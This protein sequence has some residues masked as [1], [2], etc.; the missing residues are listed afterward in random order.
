MTTKPP[1]DVVTCESDA[2]KDSSSKGDPLSSSIALINLLGKS[3]LI[4]APSMPEDALIEAT[5][6]KHNITI[7]QAMGAYRSIAGFG[8]K[9]IH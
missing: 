9:D 4:L 5:A 8:E 7:E 3:G 2:P 6:K 1:T